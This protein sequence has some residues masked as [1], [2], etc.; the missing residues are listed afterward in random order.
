MKNLKWF[1]HATFR[2]GGDK[3]IYIDPWKLKVEEEADIILI[4]HSHYDHCSPEDIKRVSG[5]KTTII[6]SPDCVSKIPQK[7]KPLSPGE[8][9]K[10]DNVIIEGIRA[11]NNNKPFHPKDKNWLGFLIFTNNQYIY[12]A[13][14]TDLIHEMR[15]L[16]VVD[17]ALLPVGGT[18]TMDG[19]EAGEAANI[20]NPKILIPYHWGDIV[21]SRKDA[22]K[23]QQIF[24]GITEILP[25]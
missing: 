25:T 15:N 11:Y 12:Y 5:P 6:A 8:K 21:G 18:Y 3:V 4:S 13:G 9:I 14:D 2:I 23:A 10:I 7:I 20:I 1:G 24:K 19:L 17:I 16:G 22:L